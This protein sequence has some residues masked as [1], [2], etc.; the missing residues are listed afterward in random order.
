LSHAA[1]L[2]LK[3]PLFIY[4]HGDYCLAL[5][6]EFKRRGL[7]LIHI[8]MDYELATQMEHVQKSDLTLT[9]PH[10]AFQALAAEFGDKIR[11]LP[12]LSMVD[13]Q[14]E[15]G[16]PRE[17]SE[18]SNLLREFSKIPRPRLGYL[19][20]LTGRASIPLLRELLSKH[21][22]WHFVS[23]GAEKWLPLPNEH[24]LPWCNQDELQGVL[25]GLDVGFL[26]YDCANPYNLHCVPLKVF[27][28]FALGMP[29]VSTPI[30]ANREYADLVYTG[31]TAD[32]LADATS[33][34][35]QEADDS[36]KKAQR[37]A[38]AREH[39]IENV[40]E[41]LRGILAGTW[42]KRAIEP[43]TIQP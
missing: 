33:R 2:Q 25:A 38:V 12:Q 20:N 13:H 28:Y 24:V 35:L 15:A 39:S 42:L 9:I 10:A 32:E 1:T 27:D 4:P 18:P 36:P 41:I 31:E 21:P 8:C 5:C 6:R 22:E 11:M 19:G 14:R 29:V 40:S 34:A 7:P 17:S 3:D 16:S 23:F 30:V 37:V 43:S 26:P